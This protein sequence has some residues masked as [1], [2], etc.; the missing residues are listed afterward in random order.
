MIAALGWKASFLVLMVVGF[1]WAGAWWAWFRDDPAE[2]PGIPADE[3]GLILKLRQDASS[4]GR[5]PPP[6]STR[7]MLRSNALWLMMGQYFAG[8]FTFFFCLTWLFPYI[9]RTYGLSYGEAGLY[10]MV[11]LLAGAAGNVV[12]GALVDRLYRTVPRWSRRLP[13]VVGFALG[14]LG[15]TMSVGQAEVAAA[16]FW[17]SVAIFGADM[18]L[19]PSW[20][21][22]IDIG[23]PHAGKVSGT[24][25][26]A[27]NLGSAVVAIAFP[28]LLAWTGGPAAFFYVGA[29]LNVLA[30]GLWLAA[31]SSRRIA[32]G[33]ISEK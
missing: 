7:E 11:P 27:G 9:Q 13:A 21:F 22:C 24:M 29:T 14:A 25:N 19:S 2:H 30:I 17:L 18:T 10:A 31:D 26:M 1:V 6:L 5:P 15:L 4:Q 16:V 8:N 23:G 20:S 28:Y 32:S 33:S 3:L 12:S